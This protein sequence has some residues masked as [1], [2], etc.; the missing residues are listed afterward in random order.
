[1]V[2]GERV[3]DVRALI[4]GYRRLECCDVSHFVVTLHL[5]V[6][7]G[8]GCANTILLVLVVTIAEVMAKLHS[9]I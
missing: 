6:V 7:S 1:V 9:D 8:E 5:I 2:V 3:A 4:M